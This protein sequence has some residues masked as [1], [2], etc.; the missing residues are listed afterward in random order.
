[1]FRI[2]TSTYPFLAAIGALRS[3]FACVCVCCIQAGICPEPLEI[4]NYMQVQGIG[5]TQASF[6]IA[7][8][9]EYENLGNFRKADLIFQEGL[10]NW[11]APH[12]KLQQYHR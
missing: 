2:S 3:F 10:K 5:V 9:E 11:A 8:S 12:D 4:Y 7:W 6:Y 1:M